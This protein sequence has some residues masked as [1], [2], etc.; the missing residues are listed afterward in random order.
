MILY[1]RLYNPSFE[2]WVFNLIILYTYHIASFHQSFDGAEC[3]TG[4]HLTILQ[5][6]II[7]TQ[8][9]HDKTVC[10]IKTEPETFEVQIVSLDDGTDGFIDNI[11]EVLVI[12][13]YLP[14]LS[15]QLL[16]VIRAKTCKG[17]YL[18]D[19]IVLTNV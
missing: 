6:V 3:G 11:I 18:I 15:T 4:S 10:A 17:E 2:E 1:A 5:R 13:H 19:N 8:T 12:G 16:G 7:V 9:L 14:N